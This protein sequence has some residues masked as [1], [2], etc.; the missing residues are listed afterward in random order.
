M[1]RFLVA[2]LAG[3][4]VVFLLL[5]VVVGTLGVV[6]YRNFAETGAE[7]LPGRIVL[8]L[9]LREALP[10]VATALPFEALG[11]PPPLTLSDA[12]LALRRAAADPRVAGVVAR[13][14]DGGQGFAATQDLVEAI[15]AF[16]ADGR[17]A[18]AWAD[19]FGELTPGNEGYY[20]ASAFDRI[21]VQPGGL[22]G[23]SGLAIEQPFLRGLLDRL[24]IEPEVVRRAGY[25]T[26]LDNLTERGLTPANREMLNDVLDSLSGQLVERVAAGRGFEGEQVRGLIDDGPF[27]AQAALDAGLIDGLA[28]GPDVEDA[29]RREG[30]N[31]AQMVG[32]DRYA[33]A[34]T[35]EDGEGGTR[36][37]LVRA[38]GPV[39]RGTGFPGET[40]AADDLADLL[41]ALGGDPAVQAV[42]LRL[43]TP[44]GSAVASETI[45][46]EIRNLRAA[47]KPVIVSM[48]NV[49]ASGGYW[50]SMG[51]SRIV[52]QPA[53]LTGSIGVIAAK[54]IIREALADL[55][56]N[57]AV[58]QRG[59]HADLWS[60]FRPYDADDRAKVEALIDDTYQDFIRGVAEGRDIDPARVREIAQGRVW[61]GERA[62]GLGLVDRLGGLPEALDEARNAL[63]L[64]ENAALD[65]RLYPEPRGP[66]EALEALLDGGGGLIRLTARLGVALSAAEGGVLARSERIEV[67]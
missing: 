10:E 30:G 40:V 54:P 17:F 22:V 2:L 43:D 52:A 63:G 14:D 49:A 64:P 56:V 7:A 53:T 19:S 61:T 62:L 13:L 15:E 18:W 38:S 11:G 9:D 21:E 35:A 59:E 65:I 4:G 57:T 1:R 31:D 26:A 16:K 32:L 29:A 46:R 60:L 8:T 66:L 12:V 42:L 55:D 37:A 20:L 39:V 28:Y 58:L 23:L 5:V 41:H 3:L 47:G 51:A 27:T 50:I 6:A 45:A 48:G 44:G 34:T 25:K 33:A 67:R 24:G 36:V